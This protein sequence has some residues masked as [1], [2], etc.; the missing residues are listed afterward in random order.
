[1]IIHSV[2]SNIHVSWYLEEKLKFGKI[3]SIRNYGYNGALTLKRHINGM[4]RL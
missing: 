3:D 2:H 1:M 4:K